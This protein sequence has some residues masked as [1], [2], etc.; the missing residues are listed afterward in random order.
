M[1]YYNINVSPI[2]VFYSKLMKIFDSP[3]FKI[4][5]SFFKQSFFIFNPNANPQIFPFDN[6]TL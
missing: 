5:T 1:L 4:V 2:L 6:T 3:S